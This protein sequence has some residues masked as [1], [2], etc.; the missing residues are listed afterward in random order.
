MDRAVAIVLACTASFV[1]P[2]AAGAGLLRCTPDE[3]QACRAQAET[4]CF[5]LKDLSKTSLC[6][7]NLLSD[8][9]QSACA[10][11]EPLFRSNR[12]AGPCRRP[13]PMVI[14]PTG[15]SPQYPPPVCP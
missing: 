6:L 15:K 2:Q 14:D 12:R 11:V 8:C 1:S 7:H 10:P 3:Q 4:L 9:E 5:E 13:D